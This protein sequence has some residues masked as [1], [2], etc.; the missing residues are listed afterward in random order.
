MSQNVPGDEP[1]ASQSGRQTAQ[2]ALTTGASAPVYAAPPPGTPMSQPAP[3]AYAPP[4]QRAPGYD[5][6]YGAPVYGAPVYAPPQSQGLA[7]ASLVIGICTA[8]MV[9]VPLLFWITFPAALVGLALGI[10][11]L[12][13]GQSRG[14]AVT[15]VVLTALVTLFLLAVFALVALGFGFFLWVAEE[16]S[17]YYG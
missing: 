11:A 16:W 2:P 10:V 9:F 4:I 13:R 3:P 15:G 7:I 17:R 14:M 5:G 6:P 12:V 8:V 1:I